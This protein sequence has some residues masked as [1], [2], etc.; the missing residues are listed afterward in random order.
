MWRVAHGLRREESPS[1]FY[2]CSA[3]ESDQGQTFMNF[4][5]LYR[6]FWARTWRAPGGWA[7][8]YVGSAGGVPSSAAQ[9]ERLHKS[10]DCAPISAATR[11][12]PVSIDIPVSTQISSM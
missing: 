9:R 2:P 1:R 11:L 5:V 3:R 10:L 4:E 8:A 7:S 6:C 12:K